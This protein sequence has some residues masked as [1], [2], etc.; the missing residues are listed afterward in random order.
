MNYQNLVSCS[1]S[2]TKNRLISQ[3]S[4]DIHEKSLETKGVPEVVVRNCS[5]IYVFL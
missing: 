5:S 2:Y 3:D 1:L 4:K